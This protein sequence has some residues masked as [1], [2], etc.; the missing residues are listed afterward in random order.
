MNKCKQMIQIICESSKLISSFAKLLH[1][2]TK[3]LYWT[4]RDLKTYFGVCQ[5]GFRLS[6]F[7]FPKIKKITLDIEKLYYYLKKCKKVN[8]FFSPLSILSVE[9][10]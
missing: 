4:T 10:S 8:G 9:Q 6:G 2:G 7:L 3:V 5:L 1:L